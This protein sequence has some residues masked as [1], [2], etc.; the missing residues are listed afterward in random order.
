MNEETH[1]RFGLDDYIIPI[2]PYSQPKIYIYMYL[3]KP[4]FHTYTYI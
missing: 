1:S 4:C 2:V 3:P